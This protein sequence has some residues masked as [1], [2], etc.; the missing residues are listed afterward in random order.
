VRSLLVSGLAL[1]LLTA[2]A[3]LSAAQSSDLAARSRVASRA[4][5]EGR[6]DEAARIYRELLQ[7]V[8]DDPGLLMNLG[9]A[10]AMGGHE[11]D[12]L[13]HLERAIAKKPDLIP[14]HLFLGSSYLAIGEPQKAVAP[15]ERVVAAQPGEIEHRRMLASAY[16]AV[17]RHAD[18]VSH[19]RRV[20]EL[21]PR[22]PGGWFALGHAYNAVAQDAI[23]TFD[24][25]SQDS[26]W[27]Q[28]LVA[29]ALLAD[30]RLTDAFANYRSVLERL[31]TMVA[32]HDSV[33]RIYQETGHRAWAVTERAR[34]ALAPAA[35]ARR[36]PLCEF[37]AG[38]HR[39]ALAAALTGSDPE[40]RY[41]R[42]RAA[43][44]LARAAFKRLEELPDSRERRE[45]RA[46]VALADRRYADAIAELKV[47][48][49]FAP[50][51]PALVD[52][53]GTAYYSARD[54]AHAVATL[55]PLVTANPDD[56]RLLTLYGDSLV[57]LQRLEEAIPLLQR[58]V[59]R[60]PGDPAPRLTLGRAYVQKGD[61]AAAIP[62]LEP[63]LAGDQDGS[64]HV[65][66]ARAYS[67]AGQKDKA[68]ALLM[69]SQELQRAAQERSAAVTGRTITPPK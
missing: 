12:A 15:L 7:A 29:D 11:S 6:F 53:L 18:A 19:L 3:S 23:A 35:C 30:G 8:P 62:L 48:L 58:A 20:T 67:G 26:P 10:L 38:R 25:A 42:V 40:S 14:A 51:D 68:D 22:L 46:T 27:S 64:V 17:G 21:A 52:D 66:L 55:G 13:V 32:I 69:K 5:S 44:E 61:F 63:Q 9:M 56:G 34:G 60:T 41:W 28:L 59:A 16:A 57:Q 54:Y 36:K 37:R 43:T 33:A 47:A 39:S 1:L 50:G 24:G 49:K 4:M 31:P 65:Q 45:M 2:A